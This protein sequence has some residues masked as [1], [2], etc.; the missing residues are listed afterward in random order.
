[1]YKL[2]RVCVVYIYL[3]ICLYRYIFI[4]KCMRVYVGMFFMFRSFLGFLIFKLFCGKKEFYFF[5][6]LVF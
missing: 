2:C 4:Y 5:E 3:C 6:E 1:M